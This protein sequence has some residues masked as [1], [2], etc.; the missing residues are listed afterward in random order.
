MKTE[1]CGTRFFNK[2]IAKSNPYKQNI[3]FILNKTVKAERIK[4]SNLP[5]RSCKF[6]V[7]KY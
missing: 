6:R 1:S 7:D 3:F 4:A 5:P 2:K